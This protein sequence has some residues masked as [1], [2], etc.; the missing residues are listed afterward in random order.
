M[1]K[2]LCEE[3]EIIQNVLKGQKELFAVL[4]NRYSSGC[5][6]YF[7]VKCGQNEETSRDLTQEAFL[8]AFRSLSTFQIGTSFRKWLRTICHHLAVD[9]FKR[10]RQ[11]RQSAAGTTQ[12]AS[13]SGHEPGIIRRHLVHQALEL[14]TERQ[15][16]VIVLKYLWNCTMEEIC[17][18]LDL[19]LG[20]AKLDLA[21]GRKRLMEVLDRAE[22]L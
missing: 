1:T 16:D 19:P 5:R 11:Q 15:H 13:E 3:D 7:W 4:V 20:T 12:T 21:Q 17:S 8:R 6:Y 18:I 2:P 9:F 10:A 22:E 14:L